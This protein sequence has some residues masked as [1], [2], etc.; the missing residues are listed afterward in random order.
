MTIS[1]IQNNRTYNKTLE[2][3]RD[4]RLLFAENETEWVRNPS[5]LT[6]P[7]VTA[8][9]QKVCLLYAVD[10]PETAVR[11]RFDMDTAGDSVVI[12]WGDGDV[13]TYTDASIGSGQTVSVEKI[14]Q[15]S[16]TVF[17]GTNAPVTFDASSDTVNSNSHGYSDGNIISFAE[18]TTT[19]GIDVNVDYYVINSSEN[20]FQISTTQN[21]T[22]VEFTNNG[23]GFILPYKQVI[24]TISS[25]TGRII[26]FDINTRHSVVGVA[27]I[28]YDTGLLDA[29]ISLPFLASA[30]SFSSV[31]TNQ[32]TRHGRLEHAAIYNLGYTTSVSRFFINCY[33]LRKVSV[34]NIPDTVTDCS[35]MFQGC[36]SLESVPDFNTKNVTTLS[37]LFLGCIN[38]RRAP[39]MD[40]SS[41]YVVDSMFIGCTN[42]VKV[43]SYNLSNCYSFTSMFNNCQSLRE[44][45][46]LDTSSA[47]SLATMFYNCVALE[48]I[49]YLDTGMCSN[50]SGMFQ[51]CTSLE[52]IPHLNL[53]HATFTNLMFN[54]CYNLI[55]IPKFDVRNVVNA[56]QMFDSC[57]S[58]EEVP[59][60]YFDSVTIV[61]NLFDD[62]Y[63]LRKIGSLG[64]SSKISNASS[65]FFSCVALEEVP[66]LN[67]KMCTT[68]LSMFSGCV[69][70]KKVPDLDL[71]NCL[72]TA[73]MFQSCVSLEK[74]PNILM[75]KNKTT[76]SMFNAC[77]NLRYIP[78]YNTSTVTD[79]AS[80][81][82]LCT[83]LEYAPQLDFSSCTTIS[84][85]FIGC[86]NLRFIPKPLGDT[87]KI[88]SITSAFSSCNSVKE[89][90]EFDFN[91]VA[92]APTTPFL[93]CWSC[94]DVKFTNLKYSFSIASAKLSSA[95]LNR[96]YESLPSVSGQTITVTGNW[97]VTGDDIT[98][99]TDKGWTVS[100]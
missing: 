14:Y 69:N 48:K 65:M 63:S 19:T 96:L 3:Y 93:T 8:D 52:Y 64:I 85:M 7:E 86:E 73:N 50:F 21:G 15:Y 41:V 20:S 2:T 1:R 84:S 88:T 43:P 44:V 39:Q 46:K 71:R 25:T 38:L 37:S 27:A 60:L 81:F 97:G 80:M 51:L 31:S 72:T 87:T 82:N 59:D 11:I 22:P 18:I 66:Q 17:D 34:L 13:Q 28:V 74:A 58:L 77:S 100:G 40:T 78:N 61:N 75:E 83:S 32:N 12:D 89:I 70:L 92:A 23:T 91:G 16:N 76:N 56:A 54:A 29:S 26:G 55:T 67:L 30:L 98:I 95:A 49:P 36:V 79:M 62:C 9:D 94:I 45:P 90:P 57:Y 99:A 6:L 4:E 42:L 24:V 47:T 5:W 33:S 68:T 35:L 53:K 10:Y